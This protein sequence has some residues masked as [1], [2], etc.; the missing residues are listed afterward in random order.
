M[1]NSSLVYAYAIVIISLTSFTVVF[2]AGRKDRA[3]TVLA[4]G[5]SSLAAALLLIFFRGNSPLLISR[6]LPFVFLGASQLFLTWGIRLL[7]GT[8][9]PWPVRFWVYTAGF[10]VLMLVLLITVPDSRV[11]QVCYFSFAVLAAGEQLLPFVRAYF[12]LKSRERTIVIAILLSFLL[13]QLFLAVYMST[14]AAPV[15]LYLSPYWITSL[16]LSI[17]FSI[18]RTGVIFLLDSARLLDD[19]SRKN[20]QLEI[21]AMKDGLTGL[22]NRHSLDQTFLGEM[23]RQDRYN[24]PLSLIML[25]VD[26]FKRVN[27]VW[28]HDAGDI[29]LAE[30]ARRVAA[31]LRDTDLLFRWGGEELLILSPHTSLEGASAVADKL[32]QVIS[33]LPILPAGN[34][35]ASFGVVERQ[36]GESRDDCFR[37]V[38]QLLYRAK[39]N[40]RNR[41]EIWTG[42]L[43]RPPAL[44]HIEWQDGWNCGVPVIDEQHRQLVR[45]GNELINLSLAD[46]ASDLQLAALDKLLSHIRLHFIDEEKIVGESGYPDLPSHAANH[47]EL[48]EE[49]LHIREKYIAGEA[50]P[51]LL[52]T[53]LVNRIVKDHMLSSDVQFFSWIFP[54]HPAETPDF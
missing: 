50:Q 38:D 51:A 49:A 52:F 18:L 35:T 31:T 17:V 27:D 4:C 26:H 33:A 14:A 48:I 5:L 16:S 8:I 6:T 45:L 42:E 32:R 22:F 11:V 19:M 24:E 7:E 23:S 3:L 10:G 20:A 1:F 29:V 47:A 28:G 15:S 25:D 40:G 53:F 43:A 34:I 36:K 13:Y 2:A 9:R 39:L 37:R 30:I 46:G 41:V 44:V 21:F 54:P 12:W